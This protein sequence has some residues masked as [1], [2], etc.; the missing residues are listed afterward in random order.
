MEVTRSSSSPFYY[1]LLIVPGLE[2]EEG[3]AGSPSLPTYV[4]M[5]GLRPQTGPTTFQCI[6]L[7]GK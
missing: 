4:R 7:E 3:L 1:A 5:A 2:L 6:E